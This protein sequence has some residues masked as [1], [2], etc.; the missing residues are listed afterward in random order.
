MTAIP[1]DV[2]VH[3]DLIYDVG[4]HRGRDTAF[5]L[6]KGFRVVAVEANPDLVREARKCFEAEIE[7]GQLAIVHAAVAERDGATTFWV[8]EDKDDW[9][10]ASPEFVRRNESFGTRHRAIE[11]PGLALESIVAEWGIPYYAKIDLEGA[12]LLC[13]RAFERFRHKPRY[14]SFEASLVDFESFF[15]EMCTVWSLG[16]RAF[17]IVNQAMNERVR[18][19][20]PP[21]EGR[22]VEELFDGHTSGPF[23]EEAP[24]AWR[25]I[26]ATLARYRRILRDSAR[27]GAAGSLAGTRWAAFDAW[28]RRFTDREPVGWYDVHAR[29]QEPAP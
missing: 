14:L 24:G 26:D 13:L 4:M 29:F 10:T 27:F 3:A 17:K 16:Y 12:D 15:T 23:G 6:A 22:F 20:R 9:G 11:V 28:L 5:Y 2:P 1:R 7:S 18:C 21:R 8:N 19:P 25:N